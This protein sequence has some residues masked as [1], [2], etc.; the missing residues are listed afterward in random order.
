MG[1]PVGAPQV[2][3]PGP[4]RRLINIEMLS[5]TVRLLV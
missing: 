2:T 1:V 3:D 5:R 4:R